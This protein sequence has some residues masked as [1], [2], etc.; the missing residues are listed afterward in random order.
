MT[1]SVPIMKM[2]VLVPP[3]IVV[4]PCGANICDVASVDGGAVTTV[5]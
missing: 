5:A 4:V 2:P 3:P 1:T